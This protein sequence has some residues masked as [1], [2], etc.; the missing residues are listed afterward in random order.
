MFGIPERAAAFD[1]GEF[2][3]IVFWWWRCGRPLECPG[4]PWIIACFFAPD[5][6]VDE[7]KYEEENAG[8]L[9]GYADGRDEVHCIPTSTILIG[10]DTAGHSEETKEMLWQECHVEA[11]GKEGE[12]PETEFV[13]RH[14]AKG[15]RIP[16]VDAREDCEQQPTD[17]NVMEV[18]HDEI[19]VAELPGEWRHGQHD[20][21]ET[22]DEELEEE[23]DAENERQLEAKLSSI[24]RCEPVEYFDTRRHRNEESGC[25]EESIRE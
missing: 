24:H 8:S 18:G 2:C 9:D 23:A 3:E 21:R 19:R 15:F 25:Y 17:Q 6:G 1:N 5:V 7:I 13:V 12:V 16:V 4:I 22:R 10:V 11:N 20:P 14:L